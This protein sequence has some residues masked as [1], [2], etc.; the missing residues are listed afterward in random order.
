MLYLRLSVTVVKN[1][2]LKVSFEAIEI[3]VICFLLICELLSS[4][5]KKSKVTDGTL[6]IKEISL[7]F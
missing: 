7:A 5:P 2:A 6:K 3:S 4:D 1:A